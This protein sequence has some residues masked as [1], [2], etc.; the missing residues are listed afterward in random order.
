M[1][2]IIPFSP[3]QT[4]YLRKRECPLP[5]QNSWLQDFT[6]GPVVKTPH[7]HRRGCGLDPSLVRELRTKILNA[8]QY[9]QKEK[10]KKKTTKSD[11]SLAPGSLSFVP[12]LSSHIVPATVSEILFFFP[13]LLSK[14]QFNSSCNH[15]KNIFW[16]LP[17]WASG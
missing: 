8:M 16:G 5:S 1:R 17:W 7:L 2:I 14:A 6:G 11:G 9:T 12:Y 15:F 4:K 13:L 3:D 10:R